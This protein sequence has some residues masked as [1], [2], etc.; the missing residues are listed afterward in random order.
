MDHYSPLAA[1]GAE[2]TVEEEHLPISSSPDRVSRTE[3]N[4]GCGADSDALEHVKWLVGVPFRASVS[5]VIWMYYVVDEARDSLQAVRA[6][7]K[8]ANSEQERRAR[9]GASLAVGHVEVQRLL[10]DAT[11]R[12]SLDCW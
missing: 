9:G 6:A 1:R 2:F 12:L 5:R 10:R 11:G 8:R 7:M 3:R 4:P